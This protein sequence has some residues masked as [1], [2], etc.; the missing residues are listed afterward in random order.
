M[1]SQM[2]VTADSSWGEH[3]P[4]RQEIEELNQPM[5]SVRLRLNYISDLQQGETD[6]SFQNIVIL[7]IEEV[8]IRIFKSI[9]QVK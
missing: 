4:L 6:P 9:A 1:T 2:D 8:N 5:V 7:I 3:S